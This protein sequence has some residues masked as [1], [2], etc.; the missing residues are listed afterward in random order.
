MKERASIIILLFGLSSCQFFQ[1]DNNE[2]LVSVHDKELYFADVSGLIPEDIS[3]EDSASFV[4]SWVDSWVKEQLLVHQAEL[5]LTTEQQ[6]IEQQLNSYRNS[7]LIY[8]YQ[9]ALVGQKMDT[10]VYDYEIKEYYEKHKQNFELK[11]HIL[12]MLYVK[13]QVEA[14]Q[15]KQLKKWYISDTENDRLLLEEYCYQ[16]AEEFSLE[17]TTWVYL[18]ELMNKVPIETN[19]PEQ[20]LQTH[21]KIELSDSTGIYLVRIKKYKIKDSVS[22][23]EL[24]KKRI[25]NI[26]LNKRK[27]AFLN[28]ME[29]DLFQSALAKGKVKYEKN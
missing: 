9:Q 23:L 22:P 6:N 18:D 29:S 24:E 28:K 19:N 8:A 4:Q 3:E 13:V 5:N 14:P 17:D 21:K 10:T 2:L 7:L 26:I 11:D 15:L 1:K 12:Q 16:F 20:Y 25:K 27:L